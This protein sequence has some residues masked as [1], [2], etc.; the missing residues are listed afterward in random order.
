MSPPPATGSTGPLS[1]FRNWV[2]LAGLVLMASSIFAFLLLFF[3]DTLAYA[4]NPYVGILTFL[5]APAFFFAGLMI[6]LF[7]AWRWRRRLAKIGG[8]AGPLRINVDLSR[9]HDRRVLAFFIPASVG[10]LLLT[11]MGSYHTYHFTE[12]VEFCGESCHTVMKPELTTYLHSPHARVACAE[13]HIGK[14]A[15]WY[16]R[17]KLSGTYQVYATLAH[18][19]PTPIPAPVKNL[20]PAQE[21]CEQCHWPKKFV[22]NLD[23]TLSYF[24][25]DQSNSLY[26]VRLL[27]KVGGDDP[28]HGPVGGIHWHMNVANRIEYFATDQARQKIP[29]VRVTD[30]QGVVTE[31]RTKEFTNDVSQMPKRTMDCMDCHNRPAHKLQ[32]P[33]SAVNLSMSLTNVDPHIDPSLPYIKT[34]AVG[35]LCRTY[36][37]Q[38]EALQTIATTLAQQFPNDP[39]IRGT[40]AAVQQIYTNNF[41]PE[42]KASWRDYPDNIGHKD[43]PGCFR[44]HDGKHLSTTGQSTIKAND[45]NACHLILAQ[46]SG[47]QLNQINAQGQKFAHPIDEYDPAYQCTDCHNGG[48]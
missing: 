1:L 36:T 11:A 32:A 16:V 39:R 27:L 9:P 12:S 19:Y 38:T 35:V 43:F 46:G 21:T 24:L 42:M 47:A 6:L 10:F 40:I 20:R 7:G 41:F 2:S 13:C 5:V 37:N 44:C 23:R 25:P 14:G 31:Y 18:K 26:S 3:L 8:G 30:P 48:L 34:N 29:W 4:S 45:C 33:E 28:T 17:S 22:G 15:T